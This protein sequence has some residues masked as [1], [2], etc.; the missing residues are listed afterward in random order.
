MLYYT[1]LSYPILSHPI[2]SYPILSYPIL[3]YPIP[4]YP[5]SSY[6]IASYCS[7]SYPLF[8]FYLFCQI[9]PECYTLSHSFDHQLERGG[10]GGMGRGRDGAE[11]EKRKEEKTCGGIMDG[12][13]AR[14]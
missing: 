3:S 8:L 5:I 13:G 11:G 2:L 4:P 6:P 10:E 7:V 14:R 12:D 9:F 1:I